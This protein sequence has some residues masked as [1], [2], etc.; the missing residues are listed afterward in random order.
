MVIEFVNLFGS[1]FLNYSQIQEY[2]IY[3]KL[4]TSGELVI[5]VNDRILDIL[6]AF[7]WRWRFNVSKKI[8]TEKLLYFL[9]SKNFDFLKL[10]VLNN[11]EPRLFKKILICKFTK[12]SVTLEKIVL[13]RKDSKIN[14]RNNSSVIHIFGPIFVCVF[15]HTKK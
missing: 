4:V 8:D 2:L 12:N 3:W 13:L 10:F 6:N 9:R 5:K 14:K 7:L 15:I 1:F 11:I